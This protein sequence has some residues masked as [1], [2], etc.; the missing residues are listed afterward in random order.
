MQLEALKV[1]CDIVNF[2]SFSRAA[3]VNNLSQPTVSRLVHQLEERLGGLLIDRSKR[4][5]QL[6]P[7]GQG[8]CEGCK[9]LIEQYLELEASLRRAHVE[10]AMTVR[11]AA[12]YSVGLW[13]MGQ[14]VGRF[15][16]DHPHVKVHIDYV[17]PNQ[18]YQK[19]LEGTADLGLVSFPRRSRELTVL[20]WREEEMVVACL[21]DHPLARLASVSPTGL[22]GEKFVAFDKGLVI[23]HKIDRFLRDHKVPVHVVLEFDNIENIKKGVEVQG[24]LAILPEPTLRQELQAGTLQAVHL[25]G[26]RLFRP[27]GIIHRRRQPPG[28]MALAF[29]DLLRSAEEGRPAEPGCNGALGE[30]NHIPRT[31]GAGNGAGTPGLKHETSSS[32]AQH[33]TRARTKRT[34]P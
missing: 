34:M 30:T 24:A 21:P 5:L 26:C 19:V 25:E 23:R 3:E 16:A 27:I 31:G 6:T 14:Y 17:H 9:R 28:S 18:V 22:Q 7:L 29:I 8:Y 12:I 1:F 32:A 4:P 15:E 10:R 33:N 20:P 2:R 13:D 11:V